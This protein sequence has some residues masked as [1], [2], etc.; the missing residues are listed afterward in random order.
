MAPNLVC[1]SFAFINKKKVTLIGFV[2]LILCYSLTL[3]HCPEVQGEMP[4]WIYIANIALLFWYQTLDAI[5]GKQARRTKSSSPL[6][7]LFDHGK[8]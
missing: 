5:D 3:Y 4:Q 7:E 2:A 8:L 1:I 6:G